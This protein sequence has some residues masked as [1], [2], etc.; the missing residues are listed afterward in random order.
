MIVTSPP[1]WGLRD[2]S[3]VKKFKEKDDAESYIADKSEVYGNL[4]NGVNVHPQFSIDYDAGKKKWIVKYSFPSIWDG[5]RGCDHEFDL[6]EIVIKSSY[7][8]DFNE[9][10]GGG[11]GKR[12]QE[13]SQQLSFREGFCSKC[14]AWL[15]SLGLEPDFNLYIKH[16]CDIFDE[17]KRIL[18]D[19]GTLWVNLGDTYYTISGGKFLN[20]NLYTT[21]AT[22]FGASS[23]NKLKEGKQL[24]Q[25]CLVGIPERFKIEMIDNRGWINRSTIIWKKPNCLPSSAKDRFTLDFEY[26]Y[27]FTKD[28]PTQYY[29]NYHIKKAQYEKPPRLDGIEGVD[30]GWVECDKCDGTGNFKG[31]E[32]NV[33]KGKGKRRKV[34]WSGADYYF[35]QQLVPYTEPLNRWGGD[36]IKQDTEKTTKYMEMQNLGS[37]SSM[38]A[39]RN[40]RLNPRDRNMRCIW[41]V[42]TR[43]FS[44][45]HFATFPPELIETPIDAGCPKYVC[46]KCGLPREKAYENYEHTG[47][48]DCG[49]NAKFRTGIVLDPFMGAGTTALVAREMGMD[50]CGI[51]LN[52]YYINMIWKRLKEAG[53]KDQTKLDRFF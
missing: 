5:K 42:S 39:G 52:P 25:K 29:V 31:K 2:Y 15:G 11:S 22:E 43:N 28:T 4:F 48:T 38:R 10:C 32:C 18:K 41:E 36:K 9:R 50:F 49:C 16:L 34:F 14:G 53:F 13:E 12:K 23:A 51:E 40:L 1:Y 20:D 45:A 17:T 6:R 30:W 26:I 21:D 47:Y 19:Y 7:N 37:S 8:K 44:G 3:E 46:Q 27:L 33:C 24:P 35:K